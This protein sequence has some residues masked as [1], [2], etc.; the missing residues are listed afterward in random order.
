MI[1][2]NEKCSFCNGTHF[3]LSTQREGKNWVCERICKSCSKNNRDISNR[4]EF[5]GIGG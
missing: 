4:H 2:R 3:I 1:D 5:I